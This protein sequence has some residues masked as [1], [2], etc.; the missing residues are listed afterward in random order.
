MFHTN[1][2]EKIKTHILC[3]A[4]FFFE[5]RALYELMSKNTEYVAAFPLQEWLRERDTMLML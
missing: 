1:V 2:V 4:I 3:S 5:N